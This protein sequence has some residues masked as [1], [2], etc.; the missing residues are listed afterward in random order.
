VP[1][2]REFYPGIC[3]T[4]EEKVRKNLSQGKEKTSVRLMKTL[5]NVQTV[6][7]TVTY[8]LSGLN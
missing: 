6:K 7:Q 5:V 3:L 8:S 1:R 4:T 2:L